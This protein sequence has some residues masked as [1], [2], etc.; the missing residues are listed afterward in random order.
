[1]AADGSKLLGDGRIVFND[2]GKH[3]TI[4]GPKFLK[5]NGWYYILAPAGGVET[6][7]QVALRSRNVYGPYE[8]GLYSVK[9]V[10]NATAGHVDIDYFRFH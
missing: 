4:E 7:Y 1:M 2:P 3:H 8:V 5:R 10:E 9:R 6:G